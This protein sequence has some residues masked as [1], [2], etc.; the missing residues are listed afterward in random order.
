MAGPGIRYHH[1][2]R[3][4]AGD[5]D[6]TLAVPQGSSGLDTQDYSLLVYQDKRDAALTGAIQH[7]DVV[8]VP[9]IWVDQ[10]VGLL[11]STYVVI[12]GYDPFVAESLALGRSSVSS[13]L[14]TLTQANLLGDFFI[15]A[16]ERQRDWWLGLLEANGRVN[17]HTFADDASLRSLVDVVPYGLPTAKPQHSKR[18]VRGVWSGVDEG[19]RIILWGGGLWPWLD[20]LT[21]IRAVAEIWRQRQDVRLIFPGTQHPAPWMEEIPTHFKAARHLAEEN[22][23]LNRAVFFGEWVP[24]T[25]WPNVLLESDLALTLHYDTLETRLA[26]RSRV[27]DYI[28][29]G[30]PIVATKGDA[31][32]DLISDYG[33]GVVVDY[34]DVKMI[35]D[36]MLQLLDMPRGEF[37]EKF[38]AVRRKLEWEKA[39]QPLLDFCMHPRRAPDKVVL[40]EDLGSP[41]YLEQRRRLVKEREHW[42]SLVQEYE[43]GWFIR[44]MRRIHHWRRIIWKKTL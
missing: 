44:F 42:R 26:F 6:V 38:A 33:L 10:I 34:Q 13:L 15:C 19:D 5:F 18:V 12:D 27:L 9:A 14:E 7:A 36:V 4:L 30:L 37:D 31:T 20:P 2:A 8:V 11:S 25:D 32:S 17:P 43:R 24:Y 29:A 41:F 23:L 22:G 21:A 39:A 1:L 16:S 3:V 40:K 35:A 28:W